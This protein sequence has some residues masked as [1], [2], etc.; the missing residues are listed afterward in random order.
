MQRRERDSLVLVLQEAN[1]KIKGPDGAAELVGIKPT[2]LL[3]ANR[4]PSNAEG[5]SYSHLSPFYQVPELIRRK[6]FANGGYSV[7]RWSTK[8]KT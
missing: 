2:T 1:W 4:G 7:L 3:S 5:S 6:Q 8:G